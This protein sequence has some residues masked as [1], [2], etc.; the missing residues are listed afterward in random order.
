MK[1]IFNIISNFTT[2]RSLNL[3][4]NFLRKR[5]SEEPLIYKVDMKGL[6]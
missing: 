1:T 5:V 2:M 4:H 6:K 3:N